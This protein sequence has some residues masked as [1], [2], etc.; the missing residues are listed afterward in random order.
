[1]ECDASDGKTWAAKMNMEILALAQLGLVRNKK[2]TS[3]TA[4]VDIFGSFRCLLA[5][6]VKKLVIEIKTRL[7]GTT[8][9]TETGLGS[10]FGRT[11]TI[12][13]NAEEYT[14][15]QT[16]EY[17]AM[18]IPERSHRFQLLHHMCVTNTEDGIIIYG[19][20]GGRP[21]RMVRVTLDYQLRQMFLQQMQGV[22]YS[23]IP[24]LANMDNDLSAQEMIKDDDSYILQLIQNG[25]LKTLN[26]MDHMYYALH[27]VKELRKHPVQ[28]AYGF[29]IKS[30]HIVMYNAT[31]GVS[32]MNVYIYV[33]M[34]VYVC[35]YEYICIGICV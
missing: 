29:N 35:V 9:A 16:L 18:A 31:M 24:W 10:S 3:L 30:A 26:D 25:D 32:N 19:Y 27:V 4:S 14:T 5:N 13:I 11:C 6:R 20:E 15:D 33:C 28:S 21:I 23:L 8:I 2:F 12:N 22:V 34:Y 17:L 7:A 1:M